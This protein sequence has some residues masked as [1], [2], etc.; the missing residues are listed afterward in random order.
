[1]INSL[2][3]EILFEIFSHMNIQEI[4]KLGEVCRLWRQYRNKAI[5]YNIEQSKLLICTSPKFHLKNTF[6]LS[7]SSYDDSTGLLDFKPTCSSTSFNV[8]ECQGLRMVLDIWQHESNDVI[9]QTCLD[10]LSP[11]LTAQY[12][13][14]YDYILSQQR[15]YLLP[16][17][18][19]L[20]NSYC[21]IGDVSSGAFILL[22]KVDIHLGIVRIVQARVSIEWILS[23][24]RRSKF[25]DKNHQ[26]QM[27]FNSISMD[28][29]VLCDS[30][31]GTILQSNS[32]SSSDGNNLDHQSTSIGRWQQL[33][34]Q[35]I[36]RN[37]NPSSIWKYHV[38]KMFVIGKS[39]VTLNDIVTKIYLGE[40][41]W[42]NAKSELLK[43]LFPHQYQS[44]PSSSS[45]SSSLFF[46]NSFISM[47][48]TMVNKN[49]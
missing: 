9:P 20:S 8:G 4:Y 35:L 48:N 40:N 22:E 30:S 27:I 31:T 34:Q 17:L 16:H 25:N 45:S 33:H 28:S 13:F 11:A 41:D 5:V 38:A 23:G 37:I 15:M 3:N 18:N 7:I 36:L 21:W 10:Q 24:Y 12:V 43:A 42:K 46:K 29:Y 49:I 6:D 39:E 44:S 47:F 1:M 19:H 14:H 26:H 32:S 2:P